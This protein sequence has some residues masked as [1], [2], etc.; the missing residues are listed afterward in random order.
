M[1][2]VIVEW[3]TTRTLLAIVWRCTQRSPKIADHRPESVNFGKEYLRTYKRDGHRVGI[4]ERG[5]QI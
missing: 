2:I 5:R 1:G 4:L 3:D